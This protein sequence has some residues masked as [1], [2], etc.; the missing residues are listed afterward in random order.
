MAEF[1]RATAADI[2]DILRLIG[3]A[4]AFIGALG[5]DQWQDG[6]PDRET[7]LRDV[8]LD[9]LYVFAEAGRVAAVAALSLL[10]EPAYDGLNGRWGVEGRY[11]TIHRMALD[12]DHRG[13]GLAAA[14]LD[15]AE[16]IARENGCGALRIDTH[17]G[18]A[19]MRRFVEKHGFLYRGEVLYPMKAGDPVRLAYEKPL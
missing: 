5:I 1:R 11:L 6:Y 8:A 14:L 18:N 15:Q 9:Q 19:A 12:D 10:P 16:R 13:G 7:L 4:R 17:Q 3:E 2:D